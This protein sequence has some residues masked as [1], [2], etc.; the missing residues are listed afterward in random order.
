MDEQAFQA[1]ANAVQPEMV[2]ES[3]QGG[4]VTHFLGLGNAKRK[5]TGKSGFI[6]V[7]EGFGGEDG[8][9]GF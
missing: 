9:R 8:K 7:F 3:Y 4:E 2:L 5:R 6:G 1:S